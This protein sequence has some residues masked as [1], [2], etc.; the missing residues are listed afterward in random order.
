MSK[1]TEYFQQADFCKSMAD[2]SV[3]FEGKARWLELASKWLALAGDG[4]T[5]DE[6][7]EA[8]VRDR[9]TGQERSRSSN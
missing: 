4:G 1:R 8:S 5:P 7:F 9:G 6:Q 3:D 2:K